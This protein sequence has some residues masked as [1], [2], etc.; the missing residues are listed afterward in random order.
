MQMPQHK[1]KQKKKNK[2]KRRRRRRKFINTI[3][4]VNQRRPLVQLDDP[5]AVLASTS[6]LTM[7]YKWLNSDGFE[8][9]LD[10]N[11]YK[12]Y[13]IEIFTSKKNQ[14]ISKTN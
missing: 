3:Y 4:L 2:N 13:N 12:K 6:T 1:N 11:L 7:L 14:F 8:E 5:F 10:S 9:Y